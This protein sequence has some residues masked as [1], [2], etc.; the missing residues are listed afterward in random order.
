MINII[1]NILG[2]SGYDI[3]TRELANA[4]ADITEVSL[5]TNL[6]SNWERNVNDKELEMIKREPDGEINLIITNPLHWKPNLNAKRNWCFLVWEG[7]KIPKCYLEEC[8]NP[9]IEYIFVP[10]EHT[11]Q[12]IKNSCVIKKGKEGKFYDARIITKIK[13]MPHGIDLNKFYPLDKLSVDG[14]MVAQEP[15]ELQDGKFESSSTDFIFLANKGFRNLEDRGG[16]QYLIKAY[17]EEFTKEDKVNLIIKINTAYGIP[18]IDNLMKELGY[19]DNSPKV[20]LDTNS[21]DY[22]D[23]VK[24]YH[25]ADVFVC[26]T[27]AESFGIPMLEAMACRIPIITTEFGG[28]TDFCSIET[29]WIIG[30]KL[31]EV[32]HDLQYE[33]IKWLTPDIKQLREAMRQAYEEKPEFMKIYSKTAL[34]TAKE[35]TWEKTAQKVINLI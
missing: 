1:G 26:P 23:L 30:G 29:G 16:T 5:Q 35:F 11:K 28:Q 3:H 8:M 21:Y 10:S 31:E 12:A 24:L 7:D 4:L 19:N 15:H 2:T 14:V 27:R 17:L 9:E 34:V 25:K 6:V 32:K 18:N 20:I 33:G 13:I 22:K